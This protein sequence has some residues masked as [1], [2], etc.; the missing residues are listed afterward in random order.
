MTVGRASHRLPLSTR[1][2][3]PTPLR[4]SNGMD[5]TLRRILACALALSASC[6]AP[7]PDA[8]SFAPGELQIVR[9]AA[10]LSWGPGPAS[11]PFECEMAILE[12]SPKQAG[13]F[14]I[15]VRTEQPWVMPPH[16]HPRAERVTVLAGRIHVGLGTD[17]ERGG[18]A[19]TAG[20]YYV[21][22]PG[23][24]HRVWADEPV[25][26]QITGIGPWEVHPAE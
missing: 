20:D 19:F 24:V 17:E 13:L 22:A 26:I 16:S 18:Q 21:N 9:R 23:M 2:T 15:R 25:E 1:P 6:A 14:T 10:S 5:K 8:H 11:V 3:R 12:G 4:L 7:P